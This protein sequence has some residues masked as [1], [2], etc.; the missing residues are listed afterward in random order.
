MWEISISCLWH[1]S[2]NLNA[3]SKDL[4]RYSLDNLQ[5]V[6]EACWCLVTIRFHVCFILKVKMLWLFW[7]KLIWEV[8]KIH[9]VQMSLKYYYS[10]HLWLNFVRKGSESSAHLPCPFV[11]PGQ[12]NFY[13][14]LGLTP[15]QL[16]WL[17]PV[18]TTSQT[19]STLGSEVLLLA[20][21]SSQDMKWHSGREPTKELEPLIPEETGSFQ[22]NRN[23]C[24]RTQN[25][26]LLFA[27]RNVLKVSDQEL[28]VTER[29][30]IIQTSH[31]K[32]T[33]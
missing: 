8:C 13:P 10:E 31:Q 30:K 9:W 22:W 15:T 4:R 16:L 7:L 27:S 2:W 21:S 1:V 28:G 3:I 6:W 29:K 20:W 11:E 12:T 32:V 17:D 25:G 5:W 33:L 26:T 19:G 24:A 18:L 14:I 23:S